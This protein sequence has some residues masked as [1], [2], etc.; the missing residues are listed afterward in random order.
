MRK[1]LK[2]LLKQTRNLPLFLQ[3]EQWRQVRCSRFLVQKSVTW[4][5]V[6]KG[7][8]FKKY[9]MGWI[10]LIIFRF[11]ELQSSD[12]SFAEKAKLVSSE[13]QELKKGMT[14]KVFINC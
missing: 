14:K 8:P 4:F 7:Y 11:E 10:P 3:Q 12:L 1:E 9:L 2:S 5:S 6:S 13:W